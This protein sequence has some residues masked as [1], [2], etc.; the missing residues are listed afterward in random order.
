MNDIPQ[1]IKAIR[2][3]AGL[4]QKQLADQ[5]GV[6]LQAVKHWEGG[7]RGVA[8]HHQLELARLGDITVKP[9]ANS[10]P[11]FVD[12]APED[13]EAASKYSWCELKYD[14]QYCE[15]RGGPGGWTITG[16]RGGVIATGSVVLPV[17]HLLMERGSLGYTA[18]TLHGPR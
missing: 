15:L 1:K 8:H 10:R 17:C 3:R 5:L 14:G 16:R 9:K 2:K 7:R 18:P 12:L 13:W 11:K 6:S 4:T